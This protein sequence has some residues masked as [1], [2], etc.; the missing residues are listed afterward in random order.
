MRSTSP[1]S[2]SEHDLS[3][4]E[5]DRFDDCESSFDSSGNLLA[6]RLKPNASGFGQATAWQTARQLQAWLRFT[7]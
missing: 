6:S 2:R 7:F 1:T 4:G 5:H 3:S